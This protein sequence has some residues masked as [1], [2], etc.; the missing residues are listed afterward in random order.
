MTNQRVSRLGLTGGLLGA[1]VG[2]GAGVLPQFFAGRMA[3]PKAPLA[4]RLDQAGPYIILATKRAATDY[5]KAIEA[6]KQLHPRAARLDFDP[7]ALDEVGARLRKIQPRYALVFIKPDELDVNFAW[8]WLETTSR[9]DDDPFVDVRTG[10]IT[11]ASPEAAAALTAR[12]ADAVGGR[13]GLPGALVD[14]LGP[15]GP[16]LKDQ[17]YFNTF[18]GSDVIPALGA[19]LS[20]RSLAHGIGCFT[21]DKLDSLKEAGVVH[22]GGH[23]HPDRIDDGLTSAQVPGLKLAPCVVF[24]GACY[25]GVTARWFD[26]TGPAVLE[27]GVAPR[28]SFCLRM[29]AKD[30]VA[31]LAAVH[32]DHGMPVYQEM[33]HLAY[34]GG[35]LGDVIKGTYDGVVL[36]A[37]GKR[38]EFERL[39]G[40]MNSPRWTAADMMLKGT[41][42]RVL[43][44]DP[45]LVLCDAFAPAPFRNA[46]EENG[47]ELRVTATVANPGLKCTFTDT[48]HNDLNTQGA[49]Q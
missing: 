42:A 34:R 4:V 7:G 27:S 43:F 12:T 5:G 45:A 36:G 35:P 14:D 25:T 8:R 38:P 44:G 24:N 29:L 40:G 30:V 22:F 37:G 21:D 9:L 32:P 46:V 49:L 2:I 47:D 19:R 41:A 13:L 31:Y 6:A 17:R 33:E 39:E 26:T 3:P 1:F 10:F 48:Y 20:L 11:G 15:P 18:G 23:G 16:E 28:A